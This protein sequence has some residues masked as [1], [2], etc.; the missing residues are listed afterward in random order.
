MARTLPQGSLS[1]GTPIWREVAVYYP[2]QPFLNLARSLECQRGYTDTQALSP[3]QVTVPS[4]GYAPA[5]TPT[6]LQPLLP[7][8]PVFV[9][10]EVSPSSSQW[11]G[12]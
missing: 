2:I 11:G 9:M 1:W 3:A 5:P 12:A 4:I 6:S 7:Q 8:Q 10:Q